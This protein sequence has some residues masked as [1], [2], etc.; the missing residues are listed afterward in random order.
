MPKPP[1]YLTV[2][3]VAARYGV[4]PRKV[5]GWI[6][7]GELLAVNVAADGAAGKTYRIN[8]AALAKFEKARAAKAGP[9]A[10]PRGGPRRRRLPA[11][12]GDGNYF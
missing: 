2:R 8:P 11:I 3:D 6:D 12:R 5:L 10:E 4:G 7:S 9:E 1:R